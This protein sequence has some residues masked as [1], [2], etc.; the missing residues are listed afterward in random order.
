MRVGGWASSRG[1]V[2][3]ARAPTAI[4]AE[5][6]WHLRKAEVRLAAME[7][8]EPPLAGLKVLRPTVH[9]D[10]RGFFLESFQEQRYR[11]VGVGVAFVQ[12][13]HSRSTRGILRGLHYQSSPGQA[14]LVR[15]TR[16]KIYDVAVDLRPA[17]PTFG[18]WFGTEL[19]DELHQQLF[20]P[21]GFAHGFCVLS[22]VAD[23]AY[24]VS[25]TYNPETEHT[26]AY[27][28]PELGVQWPLSDPIVS[29]RDASGESFAEYRRRAGR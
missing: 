7:V 3:S 10:P 8:L 20:I 18:Q 4:T 29:A 9:R 23:V 11:A 22:E 26:L 2:L 1:R 14:K 24:K 12:D 16:G 27:D 21:V 17:S 15:V 13:N 28:D 6:P 19:D 25:A 5:S